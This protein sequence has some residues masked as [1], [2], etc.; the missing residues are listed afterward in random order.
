M[1]EPAAGVPDAVATT[2]WRSTSCSQGCVSPAKKSE[3]AAALPG[4]QYCGIDT[5]NGWTRSADI[6]CRAASL[7]RRCRTARAAYCEFGFGPPEPAA[8]SVSTTGACP[9]EVTTGPD[10]LGRAAWLR[11]TGVLAPTRRSAVGDR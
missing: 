4:S 3:A 5:T 9:G 2:D 10:D 8:R 11:T 6:A 1:I 7:R